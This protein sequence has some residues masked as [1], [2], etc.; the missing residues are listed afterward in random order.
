MKKIILASAIA[1]A[2]VFTGCG[3]SGTTYVASE[4]IEE[5]I[6]VPGDN[7]MIAADG[8]STANYTYTRVGDEINV[9]CG[10]GGCGD[11]TIGSAVETPAP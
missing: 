7:I 2:F 1:A 6:P 10:D 5:E 8:N 11:V 3:S 4:P 9:D